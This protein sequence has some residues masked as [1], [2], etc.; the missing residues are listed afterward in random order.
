M[1][2]EDVIKN[3]SRF[4]ILAWSDGNEWATQFTDN[5]PE[6]KYKELLKGYEDKNLS[7]QGYHIALVKEDLILT[8]VKEY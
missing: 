3:T 4:I 5:N 7:E 6:E 1:K 8:I 2:K